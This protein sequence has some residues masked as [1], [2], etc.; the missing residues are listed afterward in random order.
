[1]KLYYAP[2]ACSLAPHIVLREVGADFT[3]ERVDLAEKRTESGADFRAINPKGYI[4]TLQLADGTVITEGIVIQQFIADQAPDAGLVPPQGT[5]ERRALEELLVFISTELHKGHSPLFNKAMPDAAKELFRDRL[6]LRYAV[7]ESSLADGRPFL[8]GERFTPAD[9]YLFTVVRW[10]RAL[11][12]DLARWPLISA[13]ADR[14]GERP[15]VKAALEA[16]G[17]AKAA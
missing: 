5:A 9:A 6:A 11:G 3:I 2:G 15:A 12:F 10:S 1:M 14:I 8:T 16:E 4:P 7:I 17:L 13:L